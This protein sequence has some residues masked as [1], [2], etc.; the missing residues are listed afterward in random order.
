MLQLT[1]L[2]FAKPR[3]DDGAF[4]SFA[5]RTHAS[6]KNALSNPPQYFF[7]EAQKERFK[8][9]PRNPRVLPTEQ[10]WADLTA[11]KAATVYRSRFGNAGGFTFVFVGSFKVGGLPSGGQDSKWKDIGLRPIAGPVEKTYNRGSDPK[12]F[13][14]M[15]IDGETKYSVQESH[16]LWSLCNIL[17][18]VYDDK[19]REEMS[20]VYGFGLNVAMDDLPYGHYEFELILPCAPEATDKLVA[21][22]VAE[23]KRIQ[24]SGVTEEELKKEL[25]S[26]R[27]T[28]EK[29]AKENRAWLW[30]LEK[31]YREGENF[32][33]V[34]NP[35]ALIKL[36]TPEALQKAAVTYLTPEKIVRFTLYPVKN[37]AA[38]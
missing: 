4:Q 2:Y 13:V 31:I 27:R 5:T 37:D 19:L 23:L 14:T 24:T 25:E 33:R 10:Q 30:K 8:Q 12:S 6:M 9:H 28:Q 3:R 17:R 21:A 22:A 35:E 1:H 38:K 34:S 26:Q 15:A 16:V 29:D 18:R 36:V 11:E 7:N 20:G 32:D